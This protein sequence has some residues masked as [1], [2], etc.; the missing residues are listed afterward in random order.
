MFST[1]G[2][3]APTTNLFGKPS[4]QPAGSSLFGG[5][6]A[7][8]TTS[9]PG[10]S[11][12]G[13]STV[14]TPATAA[15]TTPLF[16]AAPSTTAATSTPLF[17]AAPAPAATS[18]PLF[19][20][21]ATTATTA[22]TSTPLFGAAPSSTTASTPAST[23]ATTAGVTNPFGTLTTS[24]PA[25]SSLTLGTN[26]LFG[27]TPSTA[28]TNASTTVT[29]T[30]SLWSPSVVAPATGS[31]AT[32]TTTAPS[33]KAT[34]GL[35][36]TTAPSFLSNPNP[37][38]ALSTLANATKPTV[39][40]NTGAAGTTLT[41]QTMV[42]STKYAEAP[43][44]AKSELDQLH[45][46]IQSQT[47]LL[48]VLSSRPADGLDQISKDTTE[49][50]K[51]LATLSDALDRDSKVIDALQEKVAQEL[52][53][54]D[55][56]GRIIESYA[57]PRQAQFLYAN[58][59]TAEIYFLERCSQ[60]EEQLRQFRATIEEIER[61]LASFASRNPQSSHALTEVMRNQHD[62]FLAV[63]GVVAALHE[64][65]KDKEK[66]YLM[67]RRK[68]FDDA[69]DPFQANKRLRKL[70]G[71]SSA[72]STR[73]PHEESLS[74]SSSSRPFSEIARET[75]RP[76]QVTA[77]APAAAGGLGGLGAPAAAPAATTTPFGF[78]TS[79]SS[80]P[81][82]STATTSL[83]GKPATTSPFG[84]GATTTPSP[85]GAST[86]TPAP[87]FGTST[88]TA[89]TTTTTSLFGGPATSTPAFGAPA[90]AAPSLFG[91]AAPAA[92]PGL[93]FSFKK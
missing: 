6:P 18:T 23:A 56:A 9:A 38:G 73:S 65:I 31:T 84:V 8:A 35:F 67:F 5:A 75:L 88:T 3:A 59:R 76:R 34:G 39:G 2:A 87:L 15:S 4:G 7:A 48:K 22:A 10:M 51:R 1:Q 45:E 30:P 62:G 71:S 72:K 83:F 36:S 52:K 68:Y 19:G 93:G 63:A 14:A 46:F 90:T 70:G 28:A 26:P 21:A 50:S 43:A 33:T 13:G 80:A 55:S 79:F 40:A 27:P 86:T 47:H 41:K 78:S 11:L 29:A 44:D 64:E 12:F 42:S 25:S 77:A 37:A 91:G 54:T 17:G 32:T 82:A 53:Q 92:A 60:F 81:A 74:T 66:A 69:N 85:F 58:N 89:P 20:G 57:N 49:L 61:H 24:T 16:G